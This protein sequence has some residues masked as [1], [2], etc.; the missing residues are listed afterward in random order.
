MNKGNGRGNGDRLLLARLTE[1]G[2]GRRE[3]KK[4]EQT[5][6]VLGLWM[7]R[8]G[9]PRAFHPPAAHEDTHGSRCLSHSPARGCLS[10][11]SSCGQWRRPAPIAVHTGSRSERA[12][13]KMGARAEHDAA[14]VQLQFFGSFQCQSW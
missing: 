7:S 8:N 1:W 2:G 5:W 13:Y 9:P 6:W 11:H 10:F 4:E 14:L 3:E 12:G